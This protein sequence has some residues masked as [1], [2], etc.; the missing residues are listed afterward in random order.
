[1]KHPVPTRKTTVIWNAQVA[2]ALAEQGIVVQRHREMTQTSLHRHGGIEI[3]CL[4]SGGAALRW[5]K[6]DY[7]VQEGQI[8]IFGG[9]VGHQLS[10]LHGTYTR[11]VICLTDSA[12]GLAGEASGLAPDMPPRIYNLTES[13]RRDFDAAG[14]ALT[15]EL[16]K[17]NRNW[18][19]MIRVRSAL[20]LLTLDRLA[21]ENDSGEG[22]FPPLVQRALH[23]IR[24]DLREPLPLREA[25]RQL[26][27][28]AE[29]LTRI[30]RRE[31][32]KTYGCYVRELRVREARHLIET[33][34]EL[35]LGG[36]AE[37]LGFADATSFSRTF[38]AVTGVSPSR[39]RRSIRDV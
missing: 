39:L 26:N 4:E 17:I 36:I 23:M 28:S 9:A 13:R 29:Y 8:V 24:Q 18:Q 34:P 31:T 15:L 35:P 12:C 20:L 1:M 10:A 19:E 32:G 16:R 33:H 37:S 27:T 5:G 38:R 3:N 2:N 7:T 6:A 14:N 22:E 11:S 30:F 25:A 21:D